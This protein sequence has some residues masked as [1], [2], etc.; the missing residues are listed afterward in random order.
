MDNVN[1]NLVV[2]TFAAEKKKNGIESYYSALRSS[3]S[4]PAVSVVNP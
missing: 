3:G 1:W 2:N 4:V